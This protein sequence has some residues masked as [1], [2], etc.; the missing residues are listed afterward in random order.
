MSIPIDDESVSV[1]HSVGSIPLTNKKKASK[2]FAFQV[3]Q[4]RLRD[5]DIR[6]S[7]HR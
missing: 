2:L 3:V 1:C 4:E 7:L 5:L 6:V